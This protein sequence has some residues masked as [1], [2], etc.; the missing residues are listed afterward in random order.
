[1]GNN[2]PVER[3]ILP[4]YKVQ[5][6]MEPC[7]QDLHGLMDF[8]CEIVAKKLSVIANRV[9]VFLH[10]CIQRL[11]CAGRLLFIIR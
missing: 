6:P 7:A 2:G 5:V 4:A 10:K 3:S 8:I 9:F 11:A 1:M